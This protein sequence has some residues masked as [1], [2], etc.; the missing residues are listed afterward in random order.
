LIFILCRWCHSL[1]MMLHW[2]YWYAYCH[3][4]IIDSWYCH[5]Y[6]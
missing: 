3:F 6:Y 5:Y 2:H 1:L 4:L